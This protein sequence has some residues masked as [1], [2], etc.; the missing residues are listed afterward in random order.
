M[1][2]CYHA[3]VT[4]AI[5][6]ML[7]SVVNCFP[8]LSFHWESQLDEAPSHSMEKSN[9]SAAKA[10]YAAV[11]RQ[12]SKTTDDLDQSRAAR[13]LAISR[14]QESRAISPTVGDFFYRRPI[15][16]VARSFLVLG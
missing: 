11:A 12:R 1:V 15:S 7:E 14:C 3:V 9:I 6:R 13:P 16:L 8:V 10:M 4:V 2:S 5:R